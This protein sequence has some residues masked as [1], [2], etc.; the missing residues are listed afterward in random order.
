MSIRGLR[1]A[2]VAA[3]DS[4]ESI[5]SATRELLSALITANKLDPADI[6]SVIFTTTPDLT[7]EHPARSARELGWTD[8]AILCVC[9]METKKNLEKCIR[10]LIH[11][12]TDKRQDEMHH[13]Y[14]HAASGLRPDRAAANS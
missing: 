4:S 13:V 2:T 9:E 7:A 14:L 1:G 11:W 10:V 6:A 5:Y 3:T 8:T 12:N